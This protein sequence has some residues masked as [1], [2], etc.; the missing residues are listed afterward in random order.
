MDFKQIRVEKR[1]CGYWFA[2][3]GAAAICLTSAEALGCVASVLFEQAETFVRTKEEQ[4]AYFLRFRKVY[5]TDGSVEVEWAEFLEFL[6]LPFEPLVKTNEEL[7][8]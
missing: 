7:S 3:D 8:S 2:I 1:D 6:G 4:R 5:D